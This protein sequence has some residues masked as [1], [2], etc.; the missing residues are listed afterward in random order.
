[1]DDKELCMECDFVSQEECRERRKVHDE[2]IK[3]H[4]SWMHNKDVKDGKRD[5]EM[6]YQTWL[7][8]GIFSVLVAFLGI[9]VD[10]LYRG[11]V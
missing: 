10:L 9:I 8:G 4:T 11:L 3:E 2:C 6:R 5:T 7:L 1:M